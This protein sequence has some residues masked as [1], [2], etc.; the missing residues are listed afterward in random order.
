MTRL[1]ISY[2]N[3]V[4]LGTLKILRGAHSSPVFF[5]DQILLSR[6][7]LERL[8]ILSITLLLRNGFFTEFMPNGLGLFN[9]NLGNQAFL[10]QYTQLILS[11][12]HFGHLPV[13]TF[14]GD[15]EVC[16]KLLV[17]VY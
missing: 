11:L 16:V 14:N 12:L 6:V 10:L 3:L 4:V 9:F 13:E 8:N 17:L 15:F 5:D 2:R 1:V 7:G